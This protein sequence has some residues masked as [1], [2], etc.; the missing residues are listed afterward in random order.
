MQGFWSKK[1][2]KPF[3]ARLRITDGQVVFDFDDPARVAPGTGAPPTSAPADG[4][5]GMQAARFVTHDPSL[6]IPPD[7][8]LPEPP[9]A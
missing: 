7:A 8:P 1:K 9:E 6:G 3:A 2:N 5:E 4:Q